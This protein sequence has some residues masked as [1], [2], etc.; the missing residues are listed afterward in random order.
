MNNK[1]K[2]SSFDEFLR[3]ECIEFE[4][5]EIKQHI[6]SLK[7]N[8]LVFYL[9]V[10]TTLLFLLIIGVV[11]QQNRIIDSMNRIDKAC[12][13][14]LYR[15]RNCKNIRHKAFNSQNVF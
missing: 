12:L 14:R 8:K 4:E 11:W 9:S 13:Q 1:H 6:R 3:E 2:G 15:C 10:I 5:K 7:M